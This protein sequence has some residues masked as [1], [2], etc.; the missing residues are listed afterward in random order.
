MQ[1]Q[2]L[3]VLPFPSLYPKM[4]E[5][6][7]NPMARTLVPIIFAGT[8]INWNGM[9]K[10]AIVDIEDIPDNAPFLWEDI[11]YRDGYRVISNNVIFMQ[12]EFG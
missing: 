5:L 10:R 2:I 9:I 7:I 3:K 8:R 4:E 6:E 12:N 1:L 11:N